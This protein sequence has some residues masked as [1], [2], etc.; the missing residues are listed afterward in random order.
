MA[1][2][3]NG[4]DS[5]GFEDFCE[6]LYNL[7]KNHFRHANP[8]VQFT[9]LQPGMVVS[10]AQN[11]KLYHIIDQSPF[12]DEILQANMSLDTA[13]VFGGL[14]IW[15][16]AAD[17]FNVD[18]DGNVWTGSYRRG[19]TIRWQ[20][21]FDHG[22]VIDKYMKEWDITSLNTQG[23]G[24]NVIDTNP[25]HITLTTDNNAIG[26]N[27]GT[28]SEFAIV[29][30]ARRPRAEIVVEL[31][32]TVNTQF[33]FGFNNN[34]LNGMNP[35]A[36]EYVIVFFDVSDD[37]NWQIKVGDGADEE[38]FTSAIAADTDEIRLEIWVELD[39]TVH[40]AINGTEID[41]T[42]SIS[43]NKMTAD[44]HYLIVGQAQSV[45][46]AAEIAADI[47]YIEFEKFKEA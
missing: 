22:T 31:G 37:P 30:R 35:A 38:V 8:L 46:G 40:F 25:S 5:E 6:D 17:V 16:G 18:D 27:E 36:D 15:G 23:N 19:D 14:H 39:G 33:F 13:P 44:D 45:T 28:R 34:G 1:D 21:C 3:L 7:L 4:F 24:T 12:F 43:V 41:I 9:G 10:R 11:E 20:D 47:D 42:G 26:D 2:L 32:Q 29:N